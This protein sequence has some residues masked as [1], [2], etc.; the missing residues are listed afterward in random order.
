MCWLQKRKQDN[1]RIPE[2]NLLTR[3]LF[4]ALTAT[5]KINFGTA[6]AKQRQSHVN[7]AV[8]ILMHHT[9]MHFKAEAISSANVN[10]G[11]TSLRD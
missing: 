8:P 2:Q 3:S 4:A 1:E 10:I 11:A 5:Q 7:E 6:S 9:V